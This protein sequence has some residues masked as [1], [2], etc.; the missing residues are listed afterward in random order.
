MAMAEYV[1]RIGRSCLLLYILKRTYHFLMAAR[2]ALP[3]GQRST[4]VPLSGKRPVLHFCQPL[5]HSPRLDMPRNPIDA[6]VVCNELLFHLL[7]VQEPTIF[8][9]VEQGCV[10]RPAKR[11]FVLVQLF[12]IE[13]PPLFEIFHN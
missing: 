5:T 3:Y 7:H 8:G 12:F 6:P 9:V 10:A 1:I 4:P 13:K 11:I 2:I